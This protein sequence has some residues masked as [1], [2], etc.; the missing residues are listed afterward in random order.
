VTGCTQHA[1]ELSV[2]DDVLVCPKLAHSF[3][4]HLKVCT[5]SSQKVQVSELGRSIRYYSAAWKL[6]WAL[7]VFFL[8]SYAVACIGRVYTSGLLAFGKGALSPPTGLDCLLFKL[9]TEECPAV[10]CSE[11]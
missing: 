9:S 6:K 10:M 5:F 2:K 3:A 11:K 4:A 1:T 7:F 8:Y